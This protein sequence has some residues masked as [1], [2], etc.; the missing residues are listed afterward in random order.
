MQQKYAVSI[1]LAYYLIAT[2]T[3]ALGLVL[4]YDVISL[5]T[6]FSNQ[7]YVVLAKLPE[8]AKSP[9]DDSGLCCVSNNVLLSRSTTYFDPML[10]DCLSC[11][12][13]DR[14]LVSVSSS[15]AHF[16]CCAYITDLT[17]Y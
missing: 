9:G 2:P 7:N 11:V 10:T 13:F 1:K 15:G 12:D 6:I 8:S 14:H 3:L 17:Q 16:G 5:V 4:Y